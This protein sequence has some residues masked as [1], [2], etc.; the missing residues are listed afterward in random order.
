MC[1]VWHALH[2]NL[3]AASRAYQR[4]TLRDDRASGVSRIGDDQ[5]VAAAERHIECM[6]VDPMVTSVATLARRLSCVKAGNS[7]M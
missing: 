4:T 3:P 2:S 6:Q 1:A 5:V 7:Y